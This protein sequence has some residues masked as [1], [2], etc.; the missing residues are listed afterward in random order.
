MRRSTFIALHAFASAMVLGLRLANATMIY[1]DLYLSQ[2]CVRC[3]S[4][5]IRY[6]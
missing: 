4:L 6:Y 5:I 2:F 3:T 1:N